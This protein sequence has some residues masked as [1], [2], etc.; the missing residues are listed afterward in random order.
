MRWEVLV[1]AA[2][3]VAGLVVL[4]VLGKADST[5]TVPIISGIAGTL[6]PSPLLRPKTEPTLPE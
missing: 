5:I 4:T 2:V 3:L 1:L 6:L